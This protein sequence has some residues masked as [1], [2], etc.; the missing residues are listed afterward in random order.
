MQLQLHT[1]TPISYVLC[2]SFCVRVALIRIFKIGD[3][4][5][6]AGTDN[7]SY[8][9]DTTTLLSDMYAAANFLLPDNC[10]TE[11]QRGSNR[12]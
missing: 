8:V 3:T 12:L 2:E 6:P 10:E 7:N 4:L 5:N 9:L 11:S 1:A